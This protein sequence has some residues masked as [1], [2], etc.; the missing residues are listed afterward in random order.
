MLLRNSSSLLRAS[1]FF[2]ECYWAA[3][4]ELQPGQPDGDVTSAPGR[5]AIRGRSQCSIPNVECSPSFNHFS[6]F[7]E[8]C[9]LSRAGGDNTEF[10][11]IWNPERLT[12]DH[13]HSGPAYLKTKLV[14]RVHSAG[15]SLNHFDQMWTI[16]DQGKGIVSIRWILF[17]YIFVNSAYEHRLLIGIHMETELFMAWPRLWLGLSISYLLHPG[18]VFQFDTIKSVGGSPSLW[19]GHWTSGPYWSWIDSSHSPGPL[20]MTAILITIVRAGVQ[21]GMESRREMSH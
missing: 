13:N 19:A 4:S 7:S 21:L 14:S 2:P 1:H 18:I 10:S 17:A 3:T 9:G 11:P 8:D 5:P 6:S 20:F 15:V 12:S 16:L